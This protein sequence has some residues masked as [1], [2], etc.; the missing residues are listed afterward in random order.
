[1]TILELAEQLVARRDANRAEWNTSQAARELGKDRG[2]VHDYLT[3]GSRLTQE[4]R[5]LLRGT[6]WASS[7]T[8]L[9]ALARVTPPRR[10]LEEAHRLLRANPKNAKDAV[11][12][13]SQP[14]Q[15]YPDARQRLKVLAQALALRGRHGADRT[16]GKLLDPDLSAIATLLVYPNLEPKDLL[17]MQ[18]QD[19]SVRLAEKFLR[20]QLPNFNLQVGQGRES[21]AQWF[22]TELERRLGLSLPIDQ[23]LDLLAPNQKWNR[24]TLDDAITVVEGRLVAESCQNT[25]ALLRDALQMTNQ[26]REAAAKQIRARKYEIMPLPD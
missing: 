2:T 17:K 14:K 22:G 12:L 3:I 26:E 5:N 8:V 4:V 1:M 9:L 20:Q 11:A 13:I 23:V 19:E 6:R 7:T 10:Q 15:A 21:H 18:F 25:L 24:R 16:K